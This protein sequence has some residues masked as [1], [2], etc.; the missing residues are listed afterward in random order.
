MDISVLPGCFSHKFDKCKK[1][2]T[3][4]HTH[5]SKDLLV[6]SEGE[7]QHVL[8]VVV[9]HPL[10][11]LVELLIQELQVAQVTRA[12]RAQ[13]EVTQSSQRDEQG[14]DVLSCS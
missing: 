7:I 12:A 9:L 8:D 1:T 3:H 4:T 13:A 10:Q 6:D 5:L 14:I 11:A 2:H